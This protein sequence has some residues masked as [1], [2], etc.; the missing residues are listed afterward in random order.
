LI[1]S[2]SSSV[3]GLRSNC[4]LLSSLA[5]FERMIPVNAPFSQ[6][7]RTPFSISLRIVHFTFCPSLIRGTVNWLAAGAVAFLA[8][9]DVKLNK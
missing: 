3:D 4:D 2:S 1:I 5:S 9:N 6:F 7:T 8:I